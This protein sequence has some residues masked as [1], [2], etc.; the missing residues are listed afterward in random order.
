MKNNTLLSAQQIAERWGCNRTTVARIFRRY[1][2][3]GS[4]FGSA[5]QSLRRFADEDVHRIELLAR[6]GSGPGRNS[7]T[8]A[9]GQGGVQ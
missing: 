8:I 4:K 1:G 6:Q 7:G 2:V 5:Q 9:Q 3:S